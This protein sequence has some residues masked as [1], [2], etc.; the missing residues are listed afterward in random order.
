MAQNW[1]NVR[2]QPQFAGKKNQL[3]SGKKKVYFWK[4]KEILD[5]EL[6]AISEALV[7]T[8]KMTNPSRNYLIRL[9][10]ITESN[11][12]PCYISIKSGFERA[13]VP[14]DGKT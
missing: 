4:K 7:I 9:S 11:C 3:L 14:K 1:T 8:E 2:P 12:T 10:K 6:W 5:A 13:G